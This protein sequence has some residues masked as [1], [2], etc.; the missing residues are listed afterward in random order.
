MF[1]EIDGG[2]MKI[3][4]IIQ[5]Y[6]PAQLTGSEKVIAT[7]AT[8]FA[9]QPDISVVVATSD[10]RMIK[11]IY[12]PSIQR[13]PKQETIDSVRIRRLQVNWFTGSSLYVL[14]RLFPWLNSL[15]G[16]RASFM[17]FGPHLMGLEKIVREEQPDLIHTGPM[18][19][20]HVLIAAKLAKKYRIPLV[21]TPMMH[22]DVAMFENPVIYSILKGCQGV[23]T[24][25]EYEK[26]ELVKRGVAKSLITV[27]PATYLPKADFKRGSGET[28]RQAHKLANKPMVLFL[29]TKA[30]DK[31]AIH[32]LDV[33]PKVRA[34]VPDATLV[35]AGLP[36]MS[37]QKEKSVIDTTGVIDLDYLDGEAKHDALAACNLLCVPS[38][39]ESFGI[40]V[41][42]AWAKEK[43]VIGGPT[44][45]TK[46]L[47]ENGVDGYSVGFGELDELK[48][49]IVEL[50]SDPKKQLAFGKAGKRKA[51][52]FTENLIVERTQK[53]YD[54]AL[55]DFKKN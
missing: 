3:L 28:F 9:K 14:N 37:W 10:T 54:T 32:L 45:A 40:V 18:P 34:E 47:I 4:Y 42:E 8:A 41:P 26:A 23:I 2:Q 53:V 5:R 24:F 22:F 46:E 51:E 43:P 29:G 50:L 13:L 55:E 17:G 1:D 35:L 48:D 19:L 16:S 33:W 49:R 52:Q 30:F 7:V 21:I 39:T 12:D 38:R 6:L 44:G 27:I 11:G 31:G 36:T 25:T 15:T 20:Y